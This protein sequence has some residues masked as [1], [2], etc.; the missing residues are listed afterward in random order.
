MIRPSPSPRPG[1]GLSACAECMMKVPRW[2][3]F[4]MHLGRLTEMIT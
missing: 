1:R 4:C 3:R 2:V